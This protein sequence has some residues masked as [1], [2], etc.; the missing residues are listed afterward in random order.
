MHRPA[1]RFP[2]LPWSAQ[3]TLM[4]LKATVSS[5]SP[6]LRKDGDWKPQLLSY[7]LHAHLFDSESRRSCCQQVD[8]ADWCSLPCCCGPRDSICGSKARILLS[9]VRRWHMAR[10]L[11][12]RTPALGCRH[13][14]VCPSCRGKW[15]QCLLLTCGKLGERHLIQQPLFFAL[16][17]IFWH[18]VL[19]KI[20]PS[21]DVGKWHVTSL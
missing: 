15:D 20:L 5:W 14:V 2:A 3:L 12:F 17:N 13:E 18:L 9:G 19:R 1:G 7:F 11:P 10:G 6:T 4:T 21:S 8:G 16:G